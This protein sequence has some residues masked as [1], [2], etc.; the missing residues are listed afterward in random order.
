MTL[1]L[2]VAIY[3]MLYGGKTNVLCCYSG[4]QRFESH[5]EFPFLADVTVDVV[6]ALS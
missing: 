5:P 2:L 6:L 1:A 4:G 3:H